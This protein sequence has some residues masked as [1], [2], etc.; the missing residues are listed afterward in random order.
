[1]NFITTVNNMAVNM[2]E[3]IHC[4]VCVRESI[5]VHSIIGPHHMFFFANNIVY[6]ITDEVIQKKVINTGGHLFSAAYQP[7]ND[8][9][10]VPK[11]F[12]LSR[13]CSGRLCDAALLISPSN[14]DFSRLTSKNFHHSPSYPFLF[15]LNA[16]F[17]LACIFGMDSHTNKLYDHVQQSR[18]Y[19]FYLTCPHVHYF[20]QQYARF[21]R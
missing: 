16:K 18:P 20:V 1:M 3:A 11:C 10:V 9:A 8:S 21:L 15:I 14:A 2:T 5:S 12:A 7:I 6:A 19:T 4:L 17:W 13:A